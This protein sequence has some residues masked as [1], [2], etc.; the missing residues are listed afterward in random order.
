MRLIVSHSGGPKASDGKRKKANV[1]LEKEWRHNA[2]CNRSGTG[3]R[4]RD[5]LSLLFD[6]KRQ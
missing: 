2:P 4:D 1:W 3:A 5:S 6:V